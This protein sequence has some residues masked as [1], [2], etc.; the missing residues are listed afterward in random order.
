P[1]TQKAGPMRVI[2]VMSSLVIEPRPRICAE[3][4]Q[5]S[6]ATRRDGE[7]LRRRLARARKRR[8]DQQRDGD[9]ISPARARNREAKPWKATKT[10]RRLRGHGALSS[11][12]EIRLHRSSNLSC[13]DISSEIPA[14]ERAAARAGIRFRRFL[15]ERSKGP[16]AWRN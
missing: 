15:P 13:G 1:M 4:S 14:L 3:A 10:C 9:G 2:S 7:F 11:R 5:A 16:D 6:G 8:A 12:R